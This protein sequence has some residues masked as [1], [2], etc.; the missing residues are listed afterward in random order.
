MHALFA[1]AAYAGPVDDYLATLEASP[2]V[3]VSCDSVG[4]L[5][6]WLGLSEAFEEMGAEGPSEWLSAD[7]AAALGIDPSEAVVIGLDAEGLLRVDLGL[8]DPSRWETTDVGQIDAR[9]VI[10]GESGPRGRAAFDLQVDEVD[11]LALSSDVD[12]AE[13]FANRG[14]R[15][16][17][18]DCLVAMGLPAVPVSGEVIANL[19]LIVERLPEVDSYRL[20]VLGLGIPEELHA[21]F[22][23][24]EPSFLERR[25]RSTG[26][27]GY[28]YPSIALRMNM[29]PEPLLLAVSG[30]D[31]QL[32]E[33]LQPLLAQLAAAGIDLG[34]GVEVA[35]DLQKGTV[36]ARV[37]LDRPRFA[38][39]LPKRLAVALA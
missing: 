18:S 39:R 15:D 13:V 27:V 37:P 24:S 3:L 19:A 10:L 33:L 29:D 16:E 21:L 28:W 8:S 17:E 1:L 26:G 34:V 20:E 9:T 5:D 22:E 2:S 36:L 6:Q 14:A 30:S 7:G 38:R 23:G 35:A 32:G 4:A 25:R 12:L 31:P 11:R